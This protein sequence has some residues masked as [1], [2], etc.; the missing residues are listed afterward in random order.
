VLNETVAGR[1]KLERLL[2][3]GGMGEVFSAV[4]LSS[5]KRLALKRLLAHDGQRRTSAVYFMREYHAL[6]ELRHPRIIEVYD[7]GVEGDRPYYTM[8]LLDGQDLRELSP[9]PYRDACRYLRDV[10][11]SLALL[12]ARRLLHRDLSPRNVRRTSDGRCKLL[13]FGAMVPFGVPPNL[14]GTP[15]FIAP[16]ALQGG[17]IDQRSDL[18][19]LGALAYFVLTGRHAFP[20]SEVA[21]LPRAWKQP[22]ERPLRIVPELPE[23]LDELVIALMSVDASQRPGSAA[24]VIDRLSAIANLEA[25]DEVASARSFLAGSKL[26][27]RSAQ[28]EQLRRYVTRTA[29]GNGSAV[30]VCGESGSGRSRMLAEAALLGQTSGLTVVRTV[31]RSRGTTAALADD[32]VQGLLQAAPVQAQQASASRPLITARSL[33]ANSGEAR[34][35]LLRELTGFVL[36]IARARPLVISVDDL[37]RADELSRALIAALAYQCSETTL[38]VIASYDVR[39]AAPLLE[40]VQ[41]AADTVTLRALDRV[42]TIMLCAS[43]FGDVPN[44][45]RVSDWLF[46]VAAGNPKLTLQ[47]AEHLL[48]QG[49]VRYVGGTWV[50]PTEVDQA[51]PPSAAE[52]LLLRLDN[53]SGEARALA[54]LLCVSRAG[55]TPERILE[56]SQLAPALVFSALEELVRTGVLE[57]AG[58]EYAFAQEALRESLLGALDPVRRR[59]LH[60][61]WAERL[62]AGAPSEEARLE[63]GWHLV[64]TSEELRGA[65]IL[66][67]IAPDWVDR[68]VSMAVAVPALERALEIYTRHDRPLAQQLHLRSLLVMSSFLADYRLADRHAEATL[69]ALY[70]FTGLG[71]TERLVPVLGRSCAFVLGLGWTALRWCFRSRKRR[72]PSVIAAVRAYARAAMGL[73]GLRALAIDVDGL[74]VGLERMRAFEGMPHPSLRLLY[75]LAKAITL[76][77][78]GSGADIGPLVQSVIDQLN[79]RGKAPLQMNQAERT[80][81]LCGVLLLEG[82]NQCYRQRS[83]ALAHARQLEQL[84]TPLAVAAAMRISMTYHLLRGETERT[85][86]FRRLLDLRAIENGTAWQIDWV[87]FPLEGLAGITWSDLIALRRSLDSLEKLAA[88]MPAFA[89]MRDTVRMGYHF[90]RGDFAAAVRFGEQYMAAH[91]PFSLIGW[92]STY[93]QTALSYIELGQGPRALEICERALGAVPVDHLQYVVHYSTL[94]AAHATALAACGER[95]RSDQAFEA[96]LTRLRASGEHTRAF[97]MHEYRVKAAR[98]LGDRAALRAALQDMRHTALASG[99]ASAILLADSV[100]ERRARAHSSPLPPAKTEA[101]RTHSITHSEETIVTAF[102]RREHLPQR[103]AQQALHMLG[104]YASSGEGYLFWVKDGVLELAASLNQ[105]EPPVELE[106]LLSAIPVNDQVGQRSVSLSRDETSAYTVVRLWSASDHCV[107]IA[108]LRGGTSRDQMI[109]DALIADIGRA[110]DKR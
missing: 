68:R 19:S 69:D 52:A 89:N 103:R 66:A 7:Y 105:R 65:D 26:V 90:R 54:E 78:Q 107:G 27:G 42:Q 23:A 36:E 63:A 10:A 99:N 80:D 39:N 2:A 4:D 56:L 29:T 108:A 72:G 38:S 35:Q 5:G 32:L 100:S 12:H 16:E 47:L 76:H 6:S 85:Q 50:L 40:Q 64:H 75:T 91:P 102:L 104:Q 109:P 95:A 98:M 67:E 57:S 46:R 20:V 37:D 34:A 3:R 101:A 21:A 93:A 31:A 25:F 94:E 14:T 70:P 8:E 84:G 60:K 97:L 74:R 81:L 28:C 43:L 92:A 41:G 11:S 9:V 82:L 33:A 61:A 58:N 55:A 73:V 62:L 49:S 88:E 22:V 13:D 45:E 44:L 71:L 87:A 30:F 106:G 59:Q 83:D 77:N 24:E 18:Y 51:L 86:H 53:V 48:A 110:L 15:P 96:L 79:G 17:P 1:Y